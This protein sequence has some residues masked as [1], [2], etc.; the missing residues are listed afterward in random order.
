MVMRGHQR[1]LATLVLEG[2]GAACASAAQ[3]EKETRVRAA[4]DN[5]L[6]RSILG[7]AIHTF[8]PLLPGDKRTDLEWMLCR[9]L[10]SDHNTAAQAVAHVLQRHVPYRRVVGASFC[11]SL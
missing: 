9:E 1:Y 5:P 3:T 2:S 10:V 6:T 8:G 4:D 11:D 7:S